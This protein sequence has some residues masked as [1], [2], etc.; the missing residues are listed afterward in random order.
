MPTTIINGET[1]DQAYARR[2][3]EEADIDARAFQ[4][5]DR[6][7]R[8]RKPWRRWK[9]LNVLASRPA[10]PLSARSTSLRRRATDAGQTV[11]AISACPIL[12]RAA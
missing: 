1:F 4:P 11:M 10:T 9:P 8:H 7:L 12:K 6:V 3:R 2:F 5:A